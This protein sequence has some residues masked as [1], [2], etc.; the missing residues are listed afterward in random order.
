LLIAQAEGAAN[1]VTT[2]KLK[3][4][5]KFVERSICFGVSEIKG[6]YKIKNDTVFFYD[7]QL[8]KSE[9][10]YFK[11]AIIKSS[12]YQNGNKLGSL[13]RHKANND[14]LPRQTND[15]Y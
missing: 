12:N 1:C 13:V 15:N 3:E 4:N 6:Y 8:S 14:T 5:N 2:F 11:Y 7:V 10:E 9:R